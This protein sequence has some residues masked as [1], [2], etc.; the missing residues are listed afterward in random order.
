MWVLGSLAVT[1]LLLG[2]SGVCAP[3]VCLGVLY[4]SVLRGWRLALVV[5]WFAGV[6]VD[7]AYCRPFPAHMLLVP[8]AVGLGRLWRGCQLTHRLAAQAL[9]GLACG[10]AA[11]LLLTLLRGVGLPGGWPG[12][13]FRLRLVASC[14]LW[15][16][17]GL[18]LLCVALDTLSERLGLARYRQVGAEYLSGA[19]GVEAEEGIGDEDA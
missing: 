14:A 19:R 16:G 12:W 13:L 15:G 3:L 11:G 7:V 8:A 1:E 9:P 5:G 17:V 2:R 18:P 10:T 6:W 4:L